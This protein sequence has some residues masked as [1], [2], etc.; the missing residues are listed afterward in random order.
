MHLA[1]VVTGNML[2]IARQ[3]VLLCLLFGASLLRNFGP[4]GWY[5]QGAPRQ[6]AAKR[7]RKAP[8]RHAPTLA[9][10][11]IFDLHSD[12]SSANRFLLSRQPYGPFFFLFLSMSGN[13]ILPCII[14]FSK[15]RQSTT[16]VPVL[17][18]TQPITHQYQSSWRTQCPGYLGAEMTGSSRVP[19]QRAKHKENT[20]LVL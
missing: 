15:A 6:T 17:L 3:V 4:G 12:S 5:I 18:E 11:L 9:Q 1:A 13:L 7:G 20:C 10:S 19:S 8:A 14:E 2:Q 16:V